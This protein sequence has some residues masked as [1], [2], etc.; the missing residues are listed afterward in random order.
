MRHRCGDNYDLWSRLWAAIARK[1]LNF[2]VKWVKAHGLEHP[3]FIVKHDLDLYRLVGNACADKLADRA[4]EAAQIDAATASPVLK[5]LSKTQAV[6][7]RLL[8]VLSQIIRDNPRDPFG[9][10]PP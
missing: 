5:L 8:A 1:S 9:A 2:Q 4:A 10:P 6:Q 7:I 3:K